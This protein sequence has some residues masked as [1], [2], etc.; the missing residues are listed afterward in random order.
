MIIFDASS[1]VSKH[2]EGYHDDDVSDQIST[3]YYCHGYEKIQI[4]SISRR[5]PTYW[6]TVL[7]LEIWVD[8]FDVVH[9]QGGYYRNQ[10]H[11]PTSYG[12]PVMNKANTM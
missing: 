5:K 11:S 2:C 10:R 1:F 8:A 7:G 4:Q 6:L 9:H 3:E 12:V